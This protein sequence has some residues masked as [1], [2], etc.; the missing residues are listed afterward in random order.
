MKRIMIL[1]GAG[2]SAESGINTFRD[3]DG[4]WEKHD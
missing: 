4:L 1:S 2:L 3:H